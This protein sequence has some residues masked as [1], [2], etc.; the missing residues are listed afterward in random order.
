MDRQRVAAGASGNAGHMT[1]PIEEILAPKPQAQPRIYAY[2]IHDAA[3]AGLLEWAKP[4]AASCS[5]SPSS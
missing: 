5:A 1:K 3:H 4:R 2:T